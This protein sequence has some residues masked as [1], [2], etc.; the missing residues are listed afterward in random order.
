[1]KEIK[2]YMKRYPVFIFLL[3]VFVVLFFM[4]LYTPESLQD[5]YVYKFVRGANDVIDYQYPIRD[6]GDVLI[7]QYNHYM[8][9]SGRFVPH[10]FLQ[11]FDG[12]LGKGAF[13]VIN[14]LLFCLLVY[15]INRLATKEL[16]L[17]NYVLTFSLILFLVPSFKETS[18]WF[19]GSF[20]YLW[21]VVFSLFFLLLLKVYWNNQIQRW[22]WVLGVLCLFLGWTNEAAVIPIGM[23]IGG[24]LLFNVRNIYGKAVFPLILFF[25]L[26]VALT[27]FSP[28]VLYDLGKQGGNND[29]TSL[30][31]RFVT[32]GVV[33]IQL[34]IF[35]LFIL[36]LLYTK[37]W[38][39]DVYKAYVK[40]SWLYVLIVLC[41]LW[42]FFIADCHYD[43]VRY[44]IEIYSLLALL[45]LLNQITVSRTL[46]HLG[47]VLGV[48]ALVYSSFLIH[49][50]FANYQNYL[51]CKQQLLQP[52]KTLILTRTD[53]IP[54]W[55]DS[56]IMRHV[57]F[58]K[59]DVWY[60][61]CDNNFALAATY[62]KKEVSYFPKDLYDDIVMNPKKYNK[63][64]TVENCGLYA[65][66]VTAPNRKY[67][68]KYQL[69]PYDF[70]KLPKVYKS[71]AKQINRYNS[72][73]SEPRNTAIVQIRN[74]YYLVIVK[75]VLQ[76]ERE[77][78]HHIE[79]I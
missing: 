76:E 31:Q 37:Y 42:V 5:D 79:C 52:S 22:H 44:A 35:W 33:F 30:I 66:E 50:S 36:S 72:R 43:R 38:K 13:N 57:D 21:A 15:L 20:N 70:E 39:R 65:K 14:A 32:V 58:C 34:R 16:K 24:Y 56:Y 23:V 1:M 74:H 47:Y 63:F 55:A 54:G 61:G 9:H 27:V 64:S 8:Y 45:A 67:H 51:D 4:N 62:G 17:F 77:R 78:V 59:R 75:P 29:S 12:I 3:L 46:I 18:L 48:V 73:I 2:Q 10:F 25:L 69:S 11:I 28:A 7:S 49:Y 26:G 6:I 41:S 68:V 71:I 53:S 19:T 40:S 60:N